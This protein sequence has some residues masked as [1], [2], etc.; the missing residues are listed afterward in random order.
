MTQTKSQVQRSST[1]VRAHATNSGSIPSITWSSGICI[2]GWGAALQGMTMEAPVFLLVALEV[3]HN[4]WVWPW[5][6]PALWGVA[7]GG[8]YLS[9]VWP[10]RPQALWGV[11][12]GVPITA[13]P[14]RLPVLWGMALEAP[15]TVGCGPG[16]PRHCGV[17]PWRLP[18]L[19][20]GP[21]GPQHC[22]VRP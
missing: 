5:R 4:S 8:L 13:G 14:W 3:P 7:L 16:G 10:W 18:A 21:G 15:S 6:P 20:C 19:G 11:S 9:G 1:G 17:W 12:L 22:R 2:P